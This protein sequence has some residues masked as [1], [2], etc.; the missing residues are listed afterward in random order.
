MANRSP[1]GAGHNKWQKAADRQ[2]QIKSHFKSPQRPVYSLNQPL[3]QTEGQRNAGDLWTLILDLFATLKNSKN[4]AVYQTDS[5]PKRLTVPQNMPH[6]SVVYI[7]NRTGVTFIKIK[8]GGEIGK[9]D[10]KKQQ[11]PERQESIWVQQL[12]LGL[13]EAVWRCCV[14]WLLCG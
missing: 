8:A 4:K 13:I 2:A 1:R 10:K 7:Q 12:E 6:A 3:G 14:L 5:K 9:V 11:K